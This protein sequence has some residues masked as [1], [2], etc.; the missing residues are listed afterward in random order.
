VPSVALVLGAGVAVC[1]ALAGVLPGPLG[2]GAAFVAVTLFPGAGLLAALVDRPRARASH[3]A[4]AILLGLAGFALSAMWWSRVLAWDRATTLVASLTPIAA[5]AVLRRLWP[6]VS[7]FSRL[8]LGTRGDRILLALVMAATL[9]AAAPFVEYAQRSN[10]G[11]LHWFYMGHDWFKHI[12]VY[13]ALAQEN[14]IPPSNPFVATE[15]T[16]RYYLGFYLPASAAAKLIQPDTVVGQQWTLIAYALLLPAVAGVL[17][18][19]LARALGASWRGA[20]IAAALGGIAGMGLDALPALAQHALRHR[21]G[22]ALLSAS[23]FLDR[24]PDVNWWIARRQEHLLASFMWVPQHAG[25]MAGVIGI[26]VILWGAPQAP[27]ASRRALIAILAAATLF[28]SVYVGTS[29]AVLF[30]VIVG[31]SALD[32]RSDRANAADLV[33]AGAIAAL[34]AV[35]VFAYY[36]AASGGY[37]GYSLAIPPAINPR[38]GGIFAKLLP[39]SAGRLLDIPLSYAL[40]FGPHLLLGGAFLWGARRAGARV[41][42]AGADA[43]ASARPE[44]TGGAEPRVSASAANT[45]PGARTSLAP[46][47]AWSA[48]AWACGVGLIF[49]TFVVPH[50]Y[51][52]IYSRGGTLLALLLAVPAG[53]WIDRALAGGAIARGAAVL[54]C[55]LSILSSLLLAAGMWRFTHTHTIDSQTTAALEWIERESPRETRLLFTRDPLTFPHKIGYFA[56]RSFLASDDLH[57]KLFIADTTEVELL[58]ERIDDL[59]ASID[60]GT[61]DRSA[62]PRVPLALLAGPPPEALPEAGRLPAIAPGAHTPAGPAGGRVVL[63][64]AP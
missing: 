42:I 47:H 64:E 35:P 33:S 27:R 5:G 8:Q 17:L 48:L 41:T 7:D 36:Q 43:R 22:A 38:E 4:L 55:A 59:L 31:R 2:W 57:E 46:P 52:N 28:Q 32:R 37:S 63:L 19:R 45:D 54:L 3:A 11:G 29:A 56:W 49:I 1:W 62:L 51:N 18:A 34:L 10:D 13:R 12:Q 60:E 21:D 40:E 24:M 61:L 53:V 30:A 25:A 9:L 58:H 44:A 15:Q 20:L 39:G 23:A 14:A 26:L 16:F 50:G 6:P